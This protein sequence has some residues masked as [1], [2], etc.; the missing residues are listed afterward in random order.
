MCLQRIFRAMMRSPLSFV[1]LCYSDLG[2]R[3]L[4]SVCR[5]SLAECVLLPRRASERAPRNRP[6]TRPG[7]L[8]CDSR[9]ALVLRAV[10]RGGRA[11]TRRPRGC[12]R[13]ASLSSPCPRPP[14]L[15]P[16]PT[17]AARL[18]RGAEGRPGMGRSLHHLRT[19]GRTP[20]QQPQPCRHSEADSTMR[21]QDEQQRRAPASARG[22]VLPPREGG[23]SRA[24]LG[25][26]SRRICH[27]RG[28]PTSRP[29]T[30]RAPWTLR[31]GPT[32]PLQ[33]PR[34]RTRAPRTPSLSST[35][36]LPARASQPQQPPQPPPPPP[37]RGPPSAPAW[38]RPRS[39]PRRS[40]PARP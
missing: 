23:P 25:T 11:Q 26:V 2:P 27:C 22:L 38:P 35:P 15:A 19:C 28:G 37:R 8:T 12:Q 32:S 7:C 29:P 18:G 9:L 20:P 40:P 10:L 21:G 16:R 3:L 30:A 14:L 1:I 4:P 13:V 36:W 31:W 34:R 17:L 24:T 5:K 6:Q 33:R 39:R